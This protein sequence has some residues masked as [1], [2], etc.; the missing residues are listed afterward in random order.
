MIAVARRAACCSSRTFFV[1]QDHVHRPAQLLR[2][3]VGELGALRLAPA[4]ESSASN[5]AQGRIGCSAPF[6]FRRRVGLRRPRAPVV[7][8]RR[9]QDVDHGLPRVDLDRRRVHLLRILLRGSP[10]APRSAASTGHA[11]SSHQNCQARRTPGR[12]HPP[13]SPHSILHIS[14]PDSVNATPASRQAGNIIH[15]HRL[16][17]YRSVQTLSG[18][19][20]TVDLYELRAPRTR[21]TARHPAADHLATGPIAR[22]WPA[23]LARLPA[24]GTCSPVTIDRLARPPTWSWP[25]TRLPENRCRYIARQTATG[26]PSTLAASWPYD[27]TRILLPTKPSRPDLPP[28]SP[29]ASSTTRGH[30]L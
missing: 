22:I 10:D 15:W 6:S 26:R 14:G 21:H 7:R 3:A 25:R 11:T 29:S 20:F 23:T 28:T 1:Q 2:A 8:S 9:L 24:K 30:G 4:V 18:D 19:E 5:T 17:A 13:K 12:R 27:G 16:R